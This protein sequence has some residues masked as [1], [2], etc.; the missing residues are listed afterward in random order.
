MQGLRNSQLNS[1]HTWNNCHT[2]YDVVIMHGSIDMSAYHACTCYFPIVYSCIV[3]MCL[4]TSAYSVQQ[5][6]V[7]INKHKRPAGV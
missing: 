7:I 4:F 6:T 3:Y 2:L 5:I 1:Y